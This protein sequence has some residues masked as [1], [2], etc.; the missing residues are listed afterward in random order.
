M[1]SINHEFFFSQ[2]PEIVWEY[3]TNT[4]L[5]ELWLMRNDFK[6][7]VGHEFQFRTNPMPNIH[8]DGIFHCRV[9]EIIPRKKL[10]YSWK[11]GP[12]EDNNEVDSVV[13]WQLQPTDKG[14]ML[15][16]EHSGFSETANLGFYNGLTQG[17]LEKLQKLAAKMDEQKAAGVGN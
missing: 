16:L 11:A 3:L 12:G 14:T 1:A 7:L 17:W 9:L 10:S 8:F 13:V 5:M 6:P 15:S 4:E 2:A